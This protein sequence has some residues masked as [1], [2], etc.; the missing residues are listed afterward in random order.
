M[1][2]LISDP[3][4]RTVADSWSGGPATWTLSGGAAA[5]YDI[6]GTKALQANPSANVFHYSTVDTGTTDQ[7]VRTVVNWSAAT[8]TGAAA[9]VWLIARAAGTGDYYAARLSY[10]TAGSVTLDVLRR[11]GGTLSGS[12]GS[13]PVGSFANLTTTQIVVE[14]FVRGDRVAA[15]AW[16][17][18]GAE[19]SSYQVSVTDTVITAG[20]L[21]GVACRRET[22][23]TNAN[24]AAEYAE[25][26]AA[27]TGLE[28]TE[29][30][31][32]PPRVLLTVTD[33]IAGDAV[34]LYRVVAGARTL[35]RAGADGDVEDVSFLR[36]DAELP[37]GVPVHYVAVVEG[38]EYASAPVTYVLDG[39]K[40]AL[41]DAVSGLAAEVIIA[42]WPERDWV[43]DATTFR[44][45]GRNVVVAGPLGQYE[46]QVELYV[47][48]WSSGE[49]L[50]ALLRG[51][52]QGIV[53]VRQPGGY[54]GVDAYW[55]VL[56]ATERRLSQDGS[57]DRR[58][59][60]LDVAETDP[61][62]ASLEA[63]GTTL[64]DLADAYEGQTL[65]DVAA[66]YATLLLLA[67][68]DWP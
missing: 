66:D 21:A 58:M 35:V 9:T 15:K 53:Q 18:A 40:V 7:R 20:T 60:V 13:A 50:L 63:R 30:D 36:I 41:S 54:N 12:L 46:G 59:W 1:T 11:V 44:P 34:E 67:Q 26:E 24:L 39:G 43:R 55:A 68:A 14:L 2:T 31:S 62:A 38:E 19:P 51:A 27:T 8:L 32:W 61:W 57:D 42:A 22:G 48:S 16:D 49:N 25:F 64:A 23:N 47:E 3:F 4:T 33:L 45:A 6:N 10:S 52:T 37:F 28:V 17:A 65:A 56:G 29:Q 5:D